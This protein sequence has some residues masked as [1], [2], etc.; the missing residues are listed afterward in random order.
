MLE[1]QELA[2]A[3]ERGL[4][5]VDAEERAVAATQL[6]GTLEIARRRQR[7]AVADHGLD[8]EQRHVLGAQGG[9]ERVQVAEQDAREPGQAAGSGR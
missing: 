7:D 5:L 9:L 2:G 4:H 8:D 3:A 6:L 1:R